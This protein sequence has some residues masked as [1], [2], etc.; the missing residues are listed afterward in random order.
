M[1]VRAF[2]LSARYRRRMLYV[3][4]EKLAAGMGRSGRETPCEELDS[5]L[6]PLTREIV[7][8]VCAHTPWK[9]M[10]FVQ[11]LTA[12]RILCRAG[13]PTTVYMGVRKDVNG[14][15]EA[16]AWLRCG[17]VYVTGGADADT[18]AVT[19]FWGKD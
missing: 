16:H 4:F 2:F 17:N 18:Y 10:C 14:A 12:Q 11:A 8:K 9:S 15:M 5:D 19:G 13:L 3:P 1:A 7:P 6:I